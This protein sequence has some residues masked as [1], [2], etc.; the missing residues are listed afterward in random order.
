MN[1]NSTI[2]DYVT[3]YLNDGT[4]DGTSKITF[5]IANSAY[6][7]NS[8]GPYCLVSVADA[9]I[10]TANNNENVLIGMEN[11][12]NHGSSSIHTPAILGN[13]SCVT[14]DATGEYFH[15]FIPNKIAY[16]TPPRPNLITLSFIKQDKSTTLPTNGHVTLKFEYLDAIG[17]V[18]SDEVTAYTPAFS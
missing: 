3:L 13:F 9:S 7:N 8:R 15:E 4:N 16:L 10:R 18:A 12:Y 6:L 5:Q 11:I 17:L 2:C 14:G 1:Y